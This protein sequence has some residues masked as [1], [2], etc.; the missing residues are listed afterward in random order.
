M[1]NFEMNT[2]KPYSIIDRI[3]FKED[4]YFITLSN[5]NDKDKAILNMVST[6][7]GDVVDKTKLEIE[8]CTNIANGDQFYFVYGVT[9]KDKYKIAGLQSV[10]DGTML[11]GP[12]YRKSYETNHMFIVLVDDFL[13][14]FQNLQ[15]QAITYYNIDKDYNATIDETHRN[16]FN[17]IAKAYFEIKNVLMELRDAS[18]ILLSGTDVYESPLIVGNSRKFT[19]NN[20]KSVCRQIDLLDFMDDVSFYHLLNIVYGHGDSS[21][22][23]RGMV[24]DIL[25]DH[26]LV[27]LKNSLVDEEDNSKEESTPVDFEHALIAD[28]KKQIE[29]LPTKDTVKFVVDYANLVQEYYEDKSMYTSKVANLLTKF[30]TLLMRK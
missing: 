20:N 21:N 3:L 16:K 23:T 9:T 14:A 2:I 28:H 27:D 26:L 8:S 18:D 11:L 24:R 1:K 10:F 15:D 4:K 6:V 25:V 12:G 30:Y 29:N 13:K 7:L 19:F 5:N 22:I 17:A